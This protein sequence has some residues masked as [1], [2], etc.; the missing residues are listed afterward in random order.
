[1]TL[2]AARPWPEWRPSPAAPQLTAPAQ[3]GWKSIAKNRS[4][5]SAK[6]SNKIIQPGRVSFR[7]EGQ[8]LVREAMNLLTV[9]QRRVIE[10]VYYSGLSHS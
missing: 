9:E 5:F 1:M 2:I 3:A 4:M 6:T 7:F 10:I 8:K